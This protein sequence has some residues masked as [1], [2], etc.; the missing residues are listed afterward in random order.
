MYFILTEEAFQEDV[1]PAGCE[2]GVQIGAALQCWLSLRSSVQ[3][4]F[5]SSTIEDRNTGRK[6]ISNCK[7]SRR[8]CADAQLSYT[9]LNLFNH[10]KCFLWRTPQQPAF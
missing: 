2:I 9:P 3:T 10:M 1:V 5:L 6:M 4:N 8:C 7:E